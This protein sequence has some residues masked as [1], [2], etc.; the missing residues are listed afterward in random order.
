MTSGTYHVFH[1]ELKR[2]WVVHHQLNFTH[3]SLNPLEV[4]K[5]HTEDLQGE[6]AQGPLARG[7][8]HDFPMSLKT[9]SDI[10]LIC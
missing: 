5:T 4:Y 10:L 7:P 9:W 1:A 8:E 3:I 6:L 2:H